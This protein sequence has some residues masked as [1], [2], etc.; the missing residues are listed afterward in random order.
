MVSG[1]ELVVSGLGFAVSGWW[2][3]VGDWGVSS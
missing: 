2:L 1:W 3:V